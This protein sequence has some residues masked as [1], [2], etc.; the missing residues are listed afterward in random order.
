[1]ANLI[2]RPLPKQCQNKHMNKLKRQLFLMYLEMGIRRSKAKH[3]A[4]KGVC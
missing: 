3:M 4:Y 1:M 2:S